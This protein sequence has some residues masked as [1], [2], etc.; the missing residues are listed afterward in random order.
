MK[1]KITILIT[2]LIIGVQASKSV[3]V[4]TDLELIPAPRN[5]GININ[6]ASQKLTVNGA[7]ALTNLGSNPVVISSQPSLFV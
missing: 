3:P 1:N 4:G 6:Q 7:I 2:L 5:L